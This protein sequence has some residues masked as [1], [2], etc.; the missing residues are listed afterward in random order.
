MTEDEKKRREE[1]EAFRK[2]I[3]EGVSKRGLLDEIE[4][5]AEEVKRAGVGHRHVEEKIR[6]LKPE[7]GGP[8]PV[9]AMWS[10]PAKVRAKDVPQTFEGMNG[11]RHVQ[12]EPTLLRIM[13]GELFLTPFTGP[14]AKPCLAHVSPNL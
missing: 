3:E 9:S 5:E 7:S 13:Q 8:M 1:I 2:L 14:I 10:G 11:N 4:I 6:A 12:A